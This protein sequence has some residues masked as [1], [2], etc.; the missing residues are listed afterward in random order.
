MERLIALCCVLMALVVMGVVFKQA[1]SGK[2][3]LLSIRNVFLAGVVLFQLSSGAIS[4]YYQ[5]FGDTPIGDPVGSGLKFLGILA[6]FLVIFFVAYDTGWFTFGIQNRIKLRAP[7]PGVGAMIV[8]ALASLVVSGILELTL[9]NFGL[10]GILAE[11]IGIAFAAMGAGAAAWLWATRP[12]NLA[13]FLFM[14]AVVAVA[15]GLSVFE[16]FGRRGL[17]SVMV[18]AIWGVYHGGFKYISFKRAALPMAVIG[19]G[20]FI[21]V[22]AF[23]STRGE[24][25][26]GVGIVENVTRLANANIGGGMVDLLSGQDAAGCSLWVIEN[27]PEPFPYSPLASIYYVLVNPVPRI[28]WDDKPLGLGT[29]MVTQAMITGKGSEYSV[30]PGLVGHLVNDNPWLSVWLYPILLAAWF[31]I[32]D[33]LLRRFPNHPY[34]VLPLGIELGEILGIARGEMGFFIFRSVVGMASAYFGTLILARFLRAVGFSF[35]SAAEEAADQEPP[36]LS[37]SLEE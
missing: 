27:R 26:K 24:A 36:E 4:F 6:T 34:M 25:G 29:Q 32:L 7:I 9:K 2:R 31:R 11:L 10:I 21:L 16:S 1:A 20:G 14:L 35:R 17:V 37:Y 19:A 15:C 12:R 13:M 30:G 8:L 23:T 28:I 22:A 33:D 5:H 3:P 18:A